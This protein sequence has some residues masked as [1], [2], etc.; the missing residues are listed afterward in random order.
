MDQAVVCANLVVV[1]SVVLVVLVS[2]RVA[3]SCCALIPC[4]FNMKSDKLKR[5]IYQIYL[6]G[7]VD[8][9]IKNG[10]KLIKVT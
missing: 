3:I 10:K 1:L 7:L 6:Q 5:Y 8:K 9:S 4:K 2:A